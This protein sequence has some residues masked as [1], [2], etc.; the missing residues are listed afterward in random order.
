MNTNPNAK[1]R[2]ATGQ[3]PAFWVTGTNDVANGRDEVIFQNLERYIKNL[4][5][6]S[7]KRLR[8]KTRMWAVLAFTLLASMVCLPEGEGGRVVP[9]KFRS[10][11][12]EIIGDHT[13][14]S[15]DDASSKHFK[16]HK[17]GDH[18]DDSDDDTSSKHFKHHSK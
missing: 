6:L 3:S 7:S 5:N 1:S 8:Q 18:S 14:Y 4:L 11:H 15:D 2:F 9:D 16:H 12:H 17:F 10:E 13:E